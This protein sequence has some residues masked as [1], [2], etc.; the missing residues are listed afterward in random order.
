MCCKLQSLGHR[1]IG[2]A[3]VG[4]D[5]TGVSPLQPWLRAV[6][7]LVR[8]EVK[9]HLRPRQPVGPQPRPVHLPVAQL[10]PHPRFVRLH[11]VLAEDV[12]PDGPHQRGHLVRAPPGPVAEGLSPERYPHPLEGLLLAVSTRRETWGSWTSPAHPARTPR[13]HARRVGRTVTF[14]RPFQAPKRARSSSACWACLPGD[15]RFSLARFCS[16]QRIAGSSARCPHCIR[17]HRGSPW[18]NPNRN[19]R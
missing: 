10:H 6:V 11:A 19:A 16:F 1:S 15:D 8:P 17:S 18:T 12:R 9:H 14:W 13:P 4:L 2:A 3:P 7:R 5:V